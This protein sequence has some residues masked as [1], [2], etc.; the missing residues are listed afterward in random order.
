MSANGGAS[1]IWS[2]MEAAEDATAGGSETEG[3]A[4]DE[5]EEVGAAWA[6]MEPISLL[7]RGRISLSDQKQ[8]QPAPRGGS[9]LFFMSM[10]GF[11]DPPKKFW[12][13]FL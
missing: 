6:D 10:R 12:L 4:S 8:G 13:A 2:Q 7:D 9:G 1:C 5:D 11:R 3:E